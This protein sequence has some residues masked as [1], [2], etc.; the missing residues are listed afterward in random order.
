MGAAVHPHDSA[1]AIV[2]LCTAREWG[3]GTCLILR[4]RD[5]L[6]LDL[7]QQVSNG[8]GRLKVSKLTPVCSNC[9]L[10]ELSATQ[11]VLHWK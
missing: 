11:R 10:V 9:Q 6:S 5:T 4:G 1:G 8:G 3:K 7:L 2:K